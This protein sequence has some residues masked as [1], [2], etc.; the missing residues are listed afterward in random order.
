MAA[1][2]RRKGAHPMSAISEVEAARQI[3]RAIVAWTRAAPAR[4]DIRPGYPY[5]IVDPVSRALMLAAAGLIESGSRTVPGVIVDG[6]PD[7]GWVDS[8]VRD[9]TDARTLERLPVVSEIPDGFLSALYRDIGGGVTALAV[10]SR[11]RR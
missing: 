10:L 4:T 1:D 3:V 9:I 2:S 11:L 6:R 5:P 8:Q 7:P